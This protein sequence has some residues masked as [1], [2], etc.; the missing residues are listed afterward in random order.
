MKKFLQKV[1][2]NMMRR[3]FVFFL[4]P[5]LLFGEG[6][7]IYKRP[8]PETVSAWLTP[9]LYAL[10]VPQ[11]WFEENRIEE[12]MKFSFLDRQNQLE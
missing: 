1:N 3:F 6:K 4:F 9:A 10:E 8:N 11:H 7:V 12:N 5:F 2:I